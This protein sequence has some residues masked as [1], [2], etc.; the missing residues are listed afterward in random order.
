MLAFVVEVLF[1][2]V[3]FNATYLYVC[4]II[5]SFGFSSF[6]CGFIFRVSLF[7]FC[8]F[9]MR[10]VDEAKGKIM[11]LVRIKLI[12]DSSTEFVHCIRMYYK[13]MI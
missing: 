13:Y 10:K 5:F 3:L 2:F 11:N 4:F 12:F 9:E 6:E 8:F 1:C 7:Y